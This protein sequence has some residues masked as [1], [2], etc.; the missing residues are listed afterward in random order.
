MTRTR[1]STKGQLIIP[2]TVRDRHGW[3]AGTQLVIE[4]AGDAV[5]LRPA[6]SV[7]PTTLKEVLG[8]LRYKGRPKTLEEM[9]KAIAKGALEGR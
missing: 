9:E 8:C 4:D 7:G 3:R 6:A 2:K 5:V 1:L